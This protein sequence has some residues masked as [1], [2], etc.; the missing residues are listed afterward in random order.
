M[1]VDFAVRLLS[2]ESLENWVKERTNQR[3]SDIATA[4]GWKQGDYV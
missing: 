2:G 1:A 3:L 4:T